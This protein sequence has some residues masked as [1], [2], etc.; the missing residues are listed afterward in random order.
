MRLQCKRLG[1]RWYIIGLD[2]GPCGPYDNRREAE[3]DRRGLERFL[4]HENERG[5]VTQQNRRDR[6]DCD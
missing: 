5:F 1:S 3:D 6:H 4:R 2:D